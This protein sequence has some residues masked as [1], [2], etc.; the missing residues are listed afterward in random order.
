MGS[1]KEEWA[2]I[3]ELGYD[4]GTT[5]SLLKLHINIRYGEC[6]ASWRGNKRKLYPQEEEKRKCLHTPQK[7]DRLGVAMD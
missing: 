5:S 4:A 6:F 1:M 2:S 3:K 7:G